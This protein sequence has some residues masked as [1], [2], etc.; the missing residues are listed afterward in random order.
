L[1]C[2]RSPLNACDEVFKQGLVHHL[3]RNIQQ[4]IQYLGLF[5]GI[6]HTTYHH[7]A[8]QELITHLPEQC[9]ALHWLSCGLVASCQ[10][11]LYWSSRRP[12]CLD[13]VRYGAFNGRVDTQILT[14]SY[15]VDSFLGI[16]YAVAPVGN[17]RWYRSPS[18]LC[19]HCGD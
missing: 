17:L 4:R 19:G 1:G 11:E 15:R 18:S 13:R 7:E 16:P 9:A 12:E 14:V 6:R 2:L 10:P 5:A 3:L 8:K